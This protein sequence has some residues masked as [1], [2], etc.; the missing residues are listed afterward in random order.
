MHA[1]VDVDSLFV[2]LLLELDFKV[3]DIDL[4]IDDTS[5]LT[6]YVKNDL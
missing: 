5:T 6:K 2:T 3:A 4:I 1:S